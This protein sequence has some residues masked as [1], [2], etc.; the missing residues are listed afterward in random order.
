MSIPPPSSRVHQLALTNTHL[1]FISPL[2]YRSYLRFFYLLSFNVE[3]VFAFTDIRYTKTCS[4][5]VRSLH[6]IRYFYFFFHSI[7]L[8]CSSSFFLSVPLLIPLSP[9]YFCYC[10]FPPVHISTKT[11]IWPHCKSATGYFYSTRHPSFCTKYM[12]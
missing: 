7:C 1:F 12:K 4:C 9:F 5:Q 3:S 10:I 6:D 8:C 2:G 11:P